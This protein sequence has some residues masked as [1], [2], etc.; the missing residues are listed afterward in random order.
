M[1]RVATCANLWTM[2]AWQSLGPEQLRKEVPS[3]NDIE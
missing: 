3:T 1:M 2:Y